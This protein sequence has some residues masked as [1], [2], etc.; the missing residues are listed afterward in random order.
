[1]NLW[2][3]FKRLSLWNK[4]GVLGGFCSILGFLGWLLLRSPQ[5]SVEVNLTAV[6][7]PNTTQII[8]EKVTIELSPQLKPKL[9]VAPVYV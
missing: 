1:M 5:S 6:N 4:V 3:R 7:S 9:T 2:Q 8:T